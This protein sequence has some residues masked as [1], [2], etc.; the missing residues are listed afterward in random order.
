MRLTSRH[1]DAIS[2]G[3]FSKIIGPGVRTGW[4]EGTQAFAFGLSQTGSTRSGGAPSQLTAT[5][6]CEMVA[7]GA[8]DL[9]IHRTVRPALQRRHGLILQAI[10]SHLG[11]FAIV[12]NVSTRVPREDVEG[13]LYGGYFVWLRL[14]GDVSADEI[15][16]WAKAE[17]NLIVAPGSIFQVKGDESAVSL[18]QNIRLCFSWEDEDKVVK[19]VERLGKVFRNHLDH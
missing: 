17:E 19:G 13:G 6:V 16:T 9:H 2:N 7:S 12:E 11:E 10:Q 15:A 5:V 8:L 14:K 4:V 18:G 1:T 3:S